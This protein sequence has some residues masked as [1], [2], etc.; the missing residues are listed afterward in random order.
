MKSY[1][2]IISNVADK[3]MFQVGHDVDRSIPNTAMYVEC[4]RRIQ[5]WTLEELENFA[6][7]SDNPIMKKCFKELADGING[8]P[9]IELWMGR[10]Q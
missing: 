7:E 10:G 9:E 1:Y 2:D 3:E 4:V 6:D 5:I 8:V